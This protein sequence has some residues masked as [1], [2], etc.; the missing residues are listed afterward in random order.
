MI[1][2]IYVHLFGDLL[3]IYGIKNEIFAI[4]HYARAPILGSRLITP[5]SRL[6]E[7]GITVPA[8]LASAPDEGPGCRT[9]E[10]PV[11]DQGSA[12]GAETPGSRPGEVDEQPPRRADEYRQDDMSNFDH[13]K[14]QPF[15]PI[16]MAG[17]RWPDRV[18]ET[19]PRW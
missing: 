9:G 16:A 17:R 2:T 11:D 1:I 7:P 19:A 15:Q 6:G 13:R 14:Y 3:Q 12:A 5:L 10:Q 18:I 4:Y 8:P